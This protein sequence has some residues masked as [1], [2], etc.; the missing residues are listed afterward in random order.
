M[1]ALKTWVF[2]ICVASIVG[3]IVQM[4]IPNGS[5]EKV[6]KVV[7]GIFFLSCVFVPLVTLLPN[8]EYDFE[9]DSGDEVKRIAENMDYV[10]ANQTIEYANTKIT[11]AISYTLDRNNINYK[12]IDVNYNIAE[13]SSISINEIEITM[14]E[15]Y[16]GQAT[17][18]ASLLERETG[19]KTFVSIEE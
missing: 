7:V 4:L 19:I 3:A 14:E 18:A 5:M 11:D 1:S 13:D 9:L 15:E 17:E 6:M 10:T 12:K 16:K 8:I 2:S